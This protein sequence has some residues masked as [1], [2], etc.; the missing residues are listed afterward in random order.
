M[1]SSSV[2]EFGGKNTVRC[3]DLSSYFWVNL[4]INPKII[5]S[6]EPSRQRIADI[7]SA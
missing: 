7:L 4:D 3:S 2:I 1:I 6:G 5:L